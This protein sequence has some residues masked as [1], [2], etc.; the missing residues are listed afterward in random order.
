MD[1]LIKKRQSDRLE[2]LSSIYR[3][4]NGREGYRLSPAEFLGIGSDLGLPGE[5][6]TQIIRFLLSEGLITQKP[7]SEAI[8][9]THKGVLEVERQLKSTE[10]GTRS[11]ES[12]SNQ[13][14][15]IF[16]SHSG[17]DENLALALIN[18][19][20]EG[21]NVP[22]SQIRCSSIDGYRLPAGVRT[23]TQLRLEVHSAKAFIGLIT[24]NSLESA[25]VL[26]ELG[27]RW[28]ADLHMVPLLAGL[29]TDSLRGPLSEINALSCHS[30]SQ[31]HQLISDLSQLLDLPIQ[32]PAA[33]AQYVSKLSALV[34]R[35]RSLKK[36]DPT[37]GE[38]LIYEETVY[39]KPKD[40]GRDGP[41]CPNCWD[42][43]KKQI[44]LTPGA[45]RGTFYC[46]VC[47]A[48]GFR[49]NEYRQGP[50]HLHP[51]KM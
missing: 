14:I 8:A 4:T 35:S 27:A 21:L 23:D 25:Y 26:F 50:S 39:W 5:E 1:D 19:L 43:K 44:R 49:T 16:I 37:A 33:Y 32:K 28:G 18:L 10:S 51:K 34:N 46:G 42:D 6:I 3:R 30:D 2:F 38:D 45:T 11:T 47:Q 9:L 22:S 7:A 20:R 24:P 41:F 36:Q 17:K 15:L 13:N 40:G 31:L 12:S 48:S 29:S